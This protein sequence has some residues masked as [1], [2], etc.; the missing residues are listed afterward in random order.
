MRATMLSR[1]PEDLTGLRVLD[2][3]C[4]PGVM[5]AEL[6][7][8]GATVTA[9]DISPQLVEIAAKRLP[10]DHRDRGHLPRGRH[11]VG[12]PRLLRLRRRDGQ[13]DLLLAATTST[14]PSSR[15][16]ARTRAA[17]VFTV[18]PRTPSSWPSGAW[19]SSSRASDRSP[20]M[21]PHDH[22]HARAPPARPARP[23]RARLARLLHLGMSGVSSVIVTRSQIKS[24]CHPLAPLRRRRV[25][26]VA[27]GPAPAAIAVPGVGRHVLGPAAG[28]AE[29]RDD[30][31]AHGP[32]HRRRHDDRAAGAVGPVPRASRLPVGHAPLGNRLE[33][34]ALPLVR[35]AL[36]DGRARRSCRLR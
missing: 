8:R 11:A 33:A 16:G 25:G 4:G 13:P 9:A 14:P 6:A 32:R 22:R 26:R 36:A 20:V 3:G 5:T 21:Q 15:L 23:R 12:R 27:A 10:E 35:L 17:I 28:H 31:G 29:P 19:A 1:L 30:R 34:R 18:A 2:A 7:A 24:I